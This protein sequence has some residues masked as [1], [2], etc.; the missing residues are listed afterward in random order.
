MALKAYVKEHPECVG[1]AAHALCDI[2]YALPSGDEIDVLYRSAE[3]WISVEVKASI[4]DRLPRDY[5]RGLYQTIKY[6][7]VLI[8]MARAEPDRVPAKIRSVL[9]LQGKL[10][11]E[12]HALRAALD[13]TVFE[14]VGNSG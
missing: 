13:I 7:A 11:P 5:E 8:A 12:Y 2:E 10:P 4:S 14:N 9:V 3:E 1:A 6:Q